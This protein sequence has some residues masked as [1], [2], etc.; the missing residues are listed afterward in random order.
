MCKDCGCQDALRD[1]LGHH[2]HHH[3]H[4]DH[5]SDQN[6]NHYHGHSKTL[7]VE[8]HV[9]QKNDDIA[10]RNWHWLDDHGVMTLNMMSSP[11]AG[12]TALL[13]ATL[14]E[15]KNKLSIAVLVGDQQ[16]DH[17]AM[18]LRTDG[19]KVKQINTHSSCHL[20]A[21][22]IQKELGQSV[23]GDEDLLIIENVGNLV[24]P[25]AFDLGEKQKIALLSVTEGEDKPAKYPVLFHDAD[26]I[27]ITKIDLVP[28]LEWRREM[29][30]KYIRQ[31]NSNAS[32]L[33]LSATT[34]EGMQAWYDYLLQL[35]A[36]T[37]ENAA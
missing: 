32:I 13:A 17:D 9:L 12:K 7:T 16:T 37:R 28:H 8:Q 6:D 5:D 24:C 33:E 18:R 22:M 11:G 26:I 23:T 19:V 3:H 34:G 25:A 30:I 27:L 2:H 10:H 15:L 29:A 35:V 36:T 14:A 21:T 1:K 20:D 31:V 4:G